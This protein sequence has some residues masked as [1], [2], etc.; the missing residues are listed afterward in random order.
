[1]KEENFGKKCFNRNGGLPP[2]IIDAAI[3]FL[4]LYLLKFL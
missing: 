3:I 2:A 4:F 1:M